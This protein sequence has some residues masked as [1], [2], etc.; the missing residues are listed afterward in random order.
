[1]SAKNKLNN[2]MITS[3][4]GL[5][6]ALYQTNEYNI[7][8]VI[9]S[10]NH[11]SLDC[12]MNLPVYLR[13]EEIAIIKEIKKYL[14]RGR[15]NIEITIDE[16]HDHILV[17]FDKAKLRSF[18]TDLHSLATEFAPLNIN[19]S[20]QDLANYFTPNIS[21][22]IAKFIIKTVN[23]ALADLMSAKQ[24]EGEELALVLSLEWQKINDLLGDL[25][26]SCD[27]DSKVRFAHLKERAARLC[28]D[29][30]EDRLYQE[31]ALLV[32]RSDFKEEIDRLI[33]H[34]EHMRSLFIDKGPKG[35]KLDFLC[36]EMLRECSTLIAK[37]H[38]HE[39]MLKGIDLKFKIERIREQIQNIE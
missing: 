20:W 24:K 5:G 37:A 25:Q 30:D 32:E 7:N 23:L 35:R 16:N 22:N 1:M 34:S 6:R 26:N 11:K 4:T 33:A 12:H 29:I 8:I 15:I 38:D 2:F 27:V 21:H 18:F 36:Q 9:Q 13:T 28:K 19:V 39:V 17:N 14:S 3:M 31:L 10:I